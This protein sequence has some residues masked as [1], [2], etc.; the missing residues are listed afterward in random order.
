MIAVHRRVVWALLGDRLDVSVDGG[1]SF[2]TDHQPCDPRKGPGLAPTS[3]SDDGA[4]SYLLCTGAP[5]AGSSEKQVYVT[6]GA[7]ASWTRAGRPRTGGLGGTIAAG[8]DHAVLVASSSG[9]SFIYRSTDD[10]RRWGD[11]LLEDDGGLGWADLGF[12]SSSDAVVVHGPA[13]LAGV[14]NGTGGQV[15]LSGNGGRTWQTTHF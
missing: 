15:L 13:G 8:S 6:T 9:A 4:H 10:A 7:H 3:I 11:G 2:T 5:G 14:G 12:T 1:Q